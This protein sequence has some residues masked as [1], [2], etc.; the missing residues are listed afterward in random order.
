MSVSRYLHIRSL[1][2]T[3]GWDSRLSCFRRRDESLVCSVVYLSLKDVLF[4]IVQ[5]E[6]NGDCYPHTARQTGQAGPAR[7]NT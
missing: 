3:N 4:I 5:K 7:G 1:T 2:G 6:H